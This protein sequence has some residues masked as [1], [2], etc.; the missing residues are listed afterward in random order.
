MEARRLPARRSARAGL[1]ARL[2]LRQAHA[3]A[4]TRRRPATPAEFRS[5][6]GVRRR[7]SMAARIPNSSALTHEG[8]GG[9]GARAPAAPA[10]TRL[11]SGGGRGRRRPGRRPAKR[12]PRCDRRRGRP[13]FPTEQHLEHA[14]YG[15]MFAVGVAASPGTGAR[16]RGT[17]PCPGGAG[18]G[19]EG[20]R[21]RKGD[22]I[23]SYRAAG[24]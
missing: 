17:R 1:A 16:T 20:T 4:K 8:E 23:W 3:S 14:S 12:P 5:S 2:N 13:S 21:R 22:K 9:G 11:V 24:Q 18:G 19:S 6:G 15:H 7:S 10:V